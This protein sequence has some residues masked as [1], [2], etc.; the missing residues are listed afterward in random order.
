[1][2]EYVFRAQGRCAHWGGIHFG[3]ER[4]TQRAP[5][6]SAVVGLCRSVFGKYEYRWEP[7]EL[8][9]LK[10]PSQDVLTV[11]SNEYQSFDG[12]SA[13]ASTQRMRTYLYEIDIVFKARITR[14]KIAGKN[15][16]L[17]KAEEMIDRRVKQGYRRRPAYFGNSECPAHVTWIEDP[18]QV[19]AQDASALAMNENL[20]NVFFD[21]DM[22]EPDRPA[23]LAPLQIVR[24]V[25]KYPTF[26]EVKKFGLRYHLP[27][28]PAA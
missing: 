4:M 3:P 13:L 11:M 27:R 14:A 20:G 18:S 21:I 6:R 15:D 16:T 23:W 5:S 12:T 19:P 26:A 7:I 22:D 9:F 8:Q 17:V 24:G 10:A 25:V 28:V 1:M 2:Q